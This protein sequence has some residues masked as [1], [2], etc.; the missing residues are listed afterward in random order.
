MQTAATY[1]NGESI[2]APN[3]QYDD[4]DIIHVFD[5]IDLWIDGYLH[6]RYVQTAEILQTDVELVVKE[7]TWHV[8]YRVAFYNDGDLV[9]TELLTPRDMERF[10]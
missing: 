6:N 2:D 7:K 4:G 9:T 5:Y 1:E 8:N 10:E 3:P